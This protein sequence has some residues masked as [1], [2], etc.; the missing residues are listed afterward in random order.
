[1]CRISSVINLST[2]SGLYMWILLDSAGF[3]WMSSGQLYL[4]GSVKNIEL[5]AQVWFLSWK[6]LSRNG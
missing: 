4:M 2:S 1:M 5:M 3:D 6:I